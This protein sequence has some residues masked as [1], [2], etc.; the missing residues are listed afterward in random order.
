[1]TPDQVASSYDRLAPSWNN[2][3]FD[4][5]NSIAQHQRAL[6]FVTIA[7]TA[8][9]VGCGSSGRIIELLISRGFTTEGL[10]IS[11]E[12]VRLARVRHPDVQFYLSDICTWILPK[13]YDFISAWDSIWHVPLTSQRAVIEKLCMGLSS[14]G[15][16]VFSTGGVDEPDERTNSSMGEPMYHAAIGISQVLQ[17]IL[18][19][20]CHCRHLEYD[21][22]PEPHVYI[23]AQKS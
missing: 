19:A 5:A 12:M 9:D 18:A 23:V 8:L 22:Y 3:E 16:F 21:Q 15:V 4:R 13:R 1:M 10:D 14:G 11:G 2:A 6:Q 20:G 17:T 7:G